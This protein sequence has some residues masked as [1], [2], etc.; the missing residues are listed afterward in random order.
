MIITLHTVNVSLPNISHL[1]PFCLFSLLIS[2][3]SVLDFAGFITGFA[4]KDKGTC[5]MYCRSVHILRSHPCIKNPTPGIMKFTGSLNF[6]PYF[7]FALIWPIWANPCIKNCPTGHEFTI[8]AETSLILF[9]TLFLVCLTIPKNI[10]DLYRN[11]CILHYM[12]YI[13]GSWVSY[14]F[15]RPCSSLL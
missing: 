2:F 10:E 7:H 11:N 6:F 5:I 4:Y 1:F 14:N 13:Y 3:V 15:G 12:T 8:S 9:I